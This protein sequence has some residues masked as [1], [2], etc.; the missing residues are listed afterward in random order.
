[1]P[2]VSG[3]TTIGAAATQLTTSKQ[4]V[5]QLS[6]TAPAAAITIGKSDVS[7]GGAISIAGA[8]NFQLGA[9]DIVFD[10]TEVWVTGTQSQVVKWVA[11]GL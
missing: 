10:L 3:T 4:P 6:I 1:M 11:V 7:T 9:S 8:A 2:L 5:V